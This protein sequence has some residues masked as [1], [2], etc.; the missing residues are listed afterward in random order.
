MGSMIIELV[1]FYETEEGSRV[2]RAALDTANAE[3]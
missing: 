3:E 2:R 1:K